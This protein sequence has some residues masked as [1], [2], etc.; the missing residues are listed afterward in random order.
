[1]KINSLSIFFPCY[2]DKGTIQ[3]L[4]EKSIKTVKDL[5][6]EDYEIIVVDDGSADGARE[7]LLSLQN[8]IPKLKVVFHEKN[9]GYGEALKSGFAAAGKE[10]V[11]YTDG[12]AQYDVGELSLL[13]NAL[14]EEIDVVNGYKIKRRDPLNRIIIGKIYQ[15]VI[16]IVFFLKVRDVDCDFRLIR[17]SKID[18]IRLTSDG[19]SACMELSKRLQN[20]G[21]RLANVP[22]HHYK[23]VYGQSQFFKVSRITSTLIM[24]IKLWWELVLLGKFK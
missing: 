1:M 23:R 12:D 16:K 14:K 21:A 20:A 22:V 19:G 3:G 11:F 13:V 17:K 4:I 8:A 9:R 7:L 2:N 6:I 10:W 5:G 15:W 24:L 18:E